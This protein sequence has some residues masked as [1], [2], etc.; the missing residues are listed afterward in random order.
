MRKIKI[1]NSFL[2]LLLLYILGYTHLLG[3][4]YGFAK[5]LFVAFFVGVFGFFLFI[6]GLANFAKKTL[7]KEMD[8]FGGNKI[9]NENETIKVD[10]KIVE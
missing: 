2:I 1:G 3:G 10:A 6:W 9:E 8:K 5:F 7:E 4:P